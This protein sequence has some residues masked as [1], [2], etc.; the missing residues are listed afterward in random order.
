MD[1]ITVKI[2]NHWSTSI[3]IAIQVFI[4]LLNVHIHAIEQNRFHQNELHQ[5]ELHQ[6]EPSQNELSKRQFHQ[7]E[8][9]SPSKFLVEGNTEECTDK[10]KPFSKCIKRLLNAANEI[11]ILATQQQFSDATSLARER[12]RQ[13]LDGC[14]RKVKEFLECCEKEKT[15]WLAKK[16]VEL[17]RKQAE[18]LDERLFAQTGKHISDFVK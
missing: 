15:C 10:Y 12:K 16:E 5:N 9:N 6:N 14:D 7:R 13:F 4:L 17:L 3:S 1:P 11:F 2:A 18:I 8:S